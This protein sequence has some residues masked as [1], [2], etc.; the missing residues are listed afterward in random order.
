MATVLPL[1]GLRA[2]VEVGRLGS[3]KAAAHRLGVTAGAVSQQIKL[4]EG[5]MGIALFRREGHGLRMTEA[6]VRAHPTLLK[7]FDQIEAAV[8]MLESTQ[9]RRQ[10]TIS[11]MPSFAA[12]W[13]VPRLGGFTERHPD[14]E[15]RI[16]AS[17]GLADLRRDRV[18]IAIR[19]GLG[20]YPGFNSCPLFA[21]VLLPVASPAL[22]AAGPAI[23]N[24][25]DCLAYPLLH[26]T[27]RADWPLWLKAFDVD[28]L[29]ATQGTRFADDYLL[30]RAAEAGQGLALVR[31]IHARE[32]IARGRL[33]LALD[34]PWPTRFAYY[35]VTLPA[36]GRRHEVAAFAD[37][38]TRETQS[39][40]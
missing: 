29:R 12:A 36:T 33:V 10:L 5:R 9:E 2:F 27:E 23:A 38:I 20:D 16:E 40:D 25:E 24:P 3:V 4:L 32:E 21:P 13:L 6:G 18:D 19:H 26:D 17:T 14:I 39:P 7:A 15:V 35:L 1:L 8:G 30:I 11:A 34:R 28:D 37:W 31:D 22:L